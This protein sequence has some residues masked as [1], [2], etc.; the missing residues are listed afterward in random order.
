MSKQPRILA[1]TNPS[2]GAADLP[3]ALRYAVAKLKEAPDT[4]AGVIFNSLKGS[5]TDRLKSVGISVTHVADLILL[6]QEL[7]IA[8]HRGGGRNVEWQVVD[9][10]CFEEFVTKEWLECAVQALSARHAS[11]ASVRDMKKQLKAGND[12]AQP[13]TLTLEELAEMV[14]EIEQLRRQVKD[15]KLELSVQ[16]VPDPRA[17][18]NELV[19]RV[20][21]GKWGA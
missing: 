9:I 12:T 3:G 15:L 17:V 13:A 19:E 5:L 1:I 16:P 21:S 20:R 18:A 2:T 6:M 7:G 14:A 10:S 4:V 11:T 8:R